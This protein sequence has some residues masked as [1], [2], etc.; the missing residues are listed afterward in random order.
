MLCSRR[1]VV[2]RMVGFVFRCVRNLLWDCLRT[3]VCVWGGGGTCRLLALLQVSVHPQL[4][5]RSAVLRNNPVRGRE[6]GFVLR[7]LIPHVCMLCGCVLTL[8][9]TSFFSWCSDPPPGKEKKGNE[10]E[11][12]LP[13]ADVP[14]VTPRELCSPRWL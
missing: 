4:N 13:K 8:H 6:S 9:A 14:L 7:R 10:K 12:A 3:S 5:L 11:N 1:C 2:S